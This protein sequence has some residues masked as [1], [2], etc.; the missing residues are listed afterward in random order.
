MNRSDR[1]LSILLRTAPLALFLW[2]VR[3]LLLPVAL[4][5]LVAL[6]LHPWKRKIARR[7][8]RLEKPAAIG[9]TVGTLVLVVIPFGLVAVRVVI[10]VQAFLGSGLGQIVGRIQDFAARHF[11]G[12]AGRLGLPVER[13]RT[14]AVDAVQRI[15]GSIGDFAGDVASALPGQL[16]AAFLFVLALYFA[17]RDGTAA[18]RW[19]LRLV[20]FP[21]HDTDELFESVRRTV[22]GTLVGQLAVSALQGGLTILALYIFGVPGALMFGILAM[23]LSVLPLVGTIPVTLGAVIYLIAAG[24]FG[25]AAGMGVAA[26]VIGVSDNVVRPWIQSVDT[27]MHPLVTL[28]AIFGGIELMG[29]SGVF[30]GP[31]IAAI[32]L[33]ALK[34]YAHDHSH[35]TPGDPTTTVTTV[36]PAASTTPATT[37]VTKVTPAG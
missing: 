1:W 7:W 24:R 28:L 37:T 6:M 15:A 2:M 13:L 23:L 31:V 17:L 33:W 11:S 36:T 27:Q 20:P 34:L 22:H 19:V 10:S 14:G 32:A 30:L 21:T 25:A 9:L 8:P 5:A 18:V 4:G 3:S 35:P 29:W 16:V 26:L 12:I